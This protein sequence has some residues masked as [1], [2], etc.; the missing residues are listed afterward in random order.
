MAPEV[1]VAV[2]PGEH[3]C[4]RLA[5]PEDRARLTIAF[6]RDGLARGQK[7][8]Y[9]TDDVEAE[10]SVA[11][12]V[13]LDEEV[14]AAVARGQVMVRSAR[15]TFVVDGSFEIERMLE[16]ICAEHV[17][18]LGAG[19]TG[20]SVTGELD[21]LG[22]DPWC[23]QLDEYE[24]RLGEL[25]VGSSVFLCQYKPSRFASGILPRV[26]EMHGVDV[27]PELAA[28]GRDGILAAARLLPGDTLRLAGELDYESSL[29]LAEVLGAHFHGP[30]RLD[31][32]DV[33]YVDVTGMRALRGRTGQPLTIVGASEPVQRLLAL[34]AW[35]TDPGIE[36]LEPA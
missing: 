27:S 36:V 3:G 13:E 12:L 35:D 11:A 5:R 1:A 18:A 29:S 23:S 7:V 28:I 32:Q 17:A 19:Y 9:L 4:C 2:R 16:T 8:L 14:E 30:L 6:V 25:E 26:A 24:R 15:E 20:L 22:D 21:F 33:S 34:L 31:L 10:R